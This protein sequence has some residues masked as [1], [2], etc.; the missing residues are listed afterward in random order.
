MLAY[1]E[2]GEVFYIKDLGEYETL[3]KTYDLHRKNI[4]GM[5]IETEHEIMFYE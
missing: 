4:L 3:S 1:N 2:E 5:N